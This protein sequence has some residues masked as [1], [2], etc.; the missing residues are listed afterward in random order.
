[1][2]HLDWNGGSTMLDMMLSYIKNS[3][4]VGELRVTM[5]SNAWHICT[6]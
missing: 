4:N 3:K 6:N 5:R 2:N 1:M